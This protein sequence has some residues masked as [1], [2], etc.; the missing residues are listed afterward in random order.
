MM[1]AIGIIILAVFTVLLTVLG[2]WAQENQRPVRALAAELCLVAAIIGTS[3]GSVTATVLA[4]IAATIN[5]G[6]LIGKDS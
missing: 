4:A 3:Y 1:T 5:I 2:L 6:G